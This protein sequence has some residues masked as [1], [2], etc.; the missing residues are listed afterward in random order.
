MRVAQVATEAI[1]RAVLVAHDAADQHGMV[2]D[3]ENGFRRA[4]LH[5]VHGDGKGHGHQFFGVALGVLVSLYA[6]DDVGFNDLQ[7]GGDLGKADRAGRSGAG[8]FARRG[9]DE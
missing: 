1:G 3:L 8:R 9:S 6:G 2:D 7:L 4:D 5:I